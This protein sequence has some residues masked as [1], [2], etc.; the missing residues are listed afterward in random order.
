ME[1]S[2]LSKLY[3]LRQPHFV[4]LLIANILW[5]LSAYYLIPLGLLN[6]YPHIIQTSQQA[7]YMLFFGVGLFAL[8]AFNNYLVQVYRRRTIC[9]I[10]QICFFVVFALHLYA[11]DVFF[12]PLNHILRFAMGAFWGLSKMVLAGTLITDKCKSADRSLANEYISWTS[13]LSFPLAFILYFCVARFFISGVLF[14]PIITVGL[15]IF[16]LLCVKFPFRVPYEEVKRCSLDR[17]FHLKDVA[18]FAITIFITFIV[19]LLFAQVGQISLSFLFFVGL[20]LSF[21]RLFFQVET[22]LLKKELLIES[23][24]FLGFLGG[25][26]LSEN[27]LLTNFCY[28]LLGMTVGN[29]GRILQQFFTLSVSHAERSTAQNTFILGRELGLYVG[30]FVGWF[31]TFNRVSL[32]LLFLCSVVAMGLLV[33]CK[34]KASE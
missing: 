30:L 3:L 34:I 4:C 29:L 10:S 19:G 12:A 33:L 1:N 16:L 26:I 24:L 18:L 2:L 17:F 8:G 15:S 28:V 14:V 32:L 20:L 13:R 25:S 6:H 11:T 22:R 9:I 7:L 23:I 31:F 21:V 5:D 27:A